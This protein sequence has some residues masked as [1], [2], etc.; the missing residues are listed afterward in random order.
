MTKSIKSSGWRMRIKK[1][2]LLALFLGTVTV[3]F[4]RT[5]GQSPLPVEPRAAVPFGQR[6]VT[7]PTLL[8]PPPVLDSSAIVPVVDQSL[9]A[10]PLPPP[11]PL[12]EKEGVESIPQS[13]ATPTQTQTV[14]ALPPPV[15]EVI[16]EAQTADPSLN[17]DGDI[18]FQRGI[19]K[20]PNGHLAPARKAREASGQ[21]LGYTGRTPQL[22]N[23][24]TNGDFF[25]VD[26]RWRISLP[27]WDRYVWGLKLDGYHQNVF[28]GDYPVFGSQDI[29]FNVF[30]ISDT[31]YESR[32]LPLAKG[33]VQY[34]NQF[35]QSIAATLDLFKGDNSFHPSEWTVQATPFFQLRDRSFDGTHEFTALQDGFVDVQLGILSDYYDQINLRVGRQAFNADFRGFLFNDTND[36][37]RLFGNAVENRI[38]YNAYAFYL[39]QKDPITQLNEFDPRREEVY[40]ANVFWQD[41]GDLFGIDRFRG[42]TLEANVLYN[43]DHSDLNREVDD[44]YLELAMDGHIGRFNI[45]AAFIQEFGHDTNNPVS[46]QAVDINSQMAALEIV[47]PMDWFFPK[48]SVLYTSGDRGVGGKTST[49][50]DGVFDNPN[51]AGAGFSY[52]QRE[53]LAVGVAQMKNNF[54]FYPSFRNKFAT[55]SNSVNPGLLLLNVGWDARLTSRMDL[56]MNFNYYEMIDTAAAELASGIKDVSRDLGF[57]ANLGFVFKPLVIDNFTFTIGASALIPGE[58]MKDLMK[59]ADTLYT[60]FTDVTL[61]Y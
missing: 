42:L 20:F 36:A 14:E 15:S 8:P 25:R 39:T 44:V 16:E 54:T 37:V 18:E 34:Q 59:S 35:I 11:I 7:A 61:F 9:P 23:D 58:G 47:Y 33:G 43:H 31:F 40:G 38:Q 51:F 27:S 30:G 32:E 53:V 1:W 46:K 60:L 21:P 52:F 57:E 6:L 26:D 3:P 49:G 17:P 5:L 28:K 13:G 24:L 19:L 29:F 55:A 50:F 48:V 45:D 4:V 41:P 56:Q 10:T 12:L 22:P 2:P